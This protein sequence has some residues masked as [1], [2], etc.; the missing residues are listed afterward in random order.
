[1]C[2]KL[3]APEENTK[4]MCVGVS[5]LCIYGP[6]RFDKSSQEMVKWDEE[7]KRS[8]ACGVTKSLWQMENG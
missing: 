2:E 5:L 8:A 7:E 6:L 4:I 3:F 1:M